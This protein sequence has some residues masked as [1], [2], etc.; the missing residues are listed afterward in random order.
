MKQPCVVLAPHLWESAWL[1]EVQHT[2]PGR[3]PTCESSSPCKQWSAPT[4]PA[5]PSDA[6]LPRSCSLRVINTGACAQGH[7]LS[8]FL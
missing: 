6:I 5:F 3:E 4:N 2:G 8:T 7:V 1:Q